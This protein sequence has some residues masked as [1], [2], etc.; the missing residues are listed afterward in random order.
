[1]A[2]KATQK[3]KGLWAMYTITCGDEIHL[4]TSA[5]SNL[6]FLNSVALRPWTPEMC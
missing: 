5:D 6:Q 1:M 4:R 3:C 2:Y